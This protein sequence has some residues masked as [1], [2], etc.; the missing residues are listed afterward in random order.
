MTSETS[1][2]TESVA[3]AQTPDTPPEGKLSADEPYFDEAELKQFDADDSLAGSA[4][5][6]MLTILFLYTIAVMSIAAIWTYY[7]IYAD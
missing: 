1:A 5:G 6:K 4:I 3:D 2:T 7:A